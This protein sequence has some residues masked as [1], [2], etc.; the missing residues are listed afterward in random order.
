LTPESG[1]DRRLDVEEQLVREREEHELALRNKW[2][3]A[4]E[5]QERIREEHEA[6]GRVE[7]EYEKQQ[8]T[9]SRL[10]PLADDLQR[11]ES[12]DEEQQSELTRKTTEQEE[13]LRQ[14]S[15]LVAELQDRLTH[16]SERRGRSEAE[17]APEC[18]APRSRQRIHRAMSGWRNRASFAAKAVANPGGPGAP[19]DIQRRSL[20][21]L[22][23]FLAHPAKLREARA[24]I[25]S[26][27]F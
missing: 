1:I 15:G 3:L 13:A 9:I 22:L 16:E 4:A 17:R 7:A 10:E 25:G 8:A 23:T 27:L 11:I 19:A 20:A 12:E 21:P 14:K 26:G 24:V 2:Q 18:D 6:R 5:L